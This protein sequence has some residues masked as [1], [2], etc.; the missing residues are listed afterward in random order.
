MATPQFHTMSSSLLRFL[1]V[2]SIVVA[3]ASEPV[4]VLF[5][6]E[7]LCPGC[8]IFVETSLVPVYSQ[9]G[10]DVIDL[11]LIPFGNAQIQDDG[12]VECQHGVGECDANTYE[13]CAIDINPDPQ[14]YLPFIG[15]LAHTL[16]KGSS[17]EPLDPQLFQDCADSSN[18]WW[19]RIQVCHDTPETVDRLVK[20]AAA[21]TPDDHQYVPWVEIEGDHM[22]IEHLD[23]KTEVCKAFLAK[24]GSHPACDDSVGIGE[25]QDTR[26]LGAVPC[27][28]E[29]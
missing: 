22:D 8:G 20:Q 12:S 29:K 3:S 21:A 13:L 16:P 1:I 5:C 24:G 17:D 15:C 23:F 11:Q 25:E 7:A 10:P 9:L 2:A 28:H 4:K 26:A 6:E 14:D 19:S 27:L 18:L